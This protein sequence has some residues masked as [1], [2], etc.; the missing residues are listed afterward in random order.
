M[1]IFIFLLKIILFLK[2]YSCIL[3][4]LSYHTQSKGPLPPHPS[5]NSNDKVKG[6]RE[7]TSDTVDRERISALRETVEIFDR[8][9]KGERV[10]YPPRTKDRGITS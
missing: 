7:D 1:V 2:V 4:A 8:S 9:V 6:P 5:N 3:A 10:G